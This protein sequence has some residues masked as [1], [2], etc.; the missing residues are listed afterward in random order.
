MRPL[1][2]IACALS[3]VLLASACSRLTFVKPDMGS[4][5]YEDLT[6]DYEFRDTPETRCR[7][8]VRGHLA[9][10]T[11]AF[12]RGL[13]DEAATDAGAALELDERS[14]DSNT[15]LLMVEDRRGH[16]DSAGG[17]SA[18]AG[19]QAHEQCPA[20]NHSEAPRD[21]DES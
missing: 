14:A 12:R 9:L 21:G 17:F 2:A 1:C 10:A 15:L 11:N 18:R 20:L 8:E 5:E 6:P 3:L 7:T 4:R 16:N 19:A 13:L